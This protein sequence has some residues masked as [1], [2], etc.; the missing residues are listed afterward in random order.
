MPCRCSS[1][2]PGKIL[3]G[4]IKEMLR[5]AYATVLIDPKK[6]EQEKVYIYPGEY[7]QVGYIVVGIMSYIHKTA[8]F[9][10]HLSQE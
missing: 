6:L 9:R 3:F 8:V 1:W 4:R 5:T 7:I 2:A 10:D